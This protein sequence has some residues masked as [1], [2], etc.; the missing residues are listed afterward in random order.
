MRGEGIGIVEGVSVLGAHANRGCA[1]GS[2][3]L[4]QAKVGAIDKYPVGFGRAGG[5]MDCQGLI[6]LDTDSESFLCD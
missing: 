1:R 2:R 5:L 3:D 6:Y 4:N